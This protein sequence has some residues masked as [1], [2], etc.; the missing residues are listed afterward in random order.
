MRD[1]VEWSRSLAGAASRTSSAD[2]HGEYPQASRMFNSAV[3]PQAET[4]NCTAELLRISSTLLSH[5]DSTMPLS[6]PSISPIPHDLVFSVPRGSRRHS[7]GGLL[8]L[9]LPAAGY[10][11]N[12]STVD[13]QQTVP[14]CVPRRSPQV[15]NQPGAHQKSS[16]HQESRTKRLPW[17]AAAETGERLDSANESG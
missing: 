3:G 15:N 12:C 6:L 13:R 10:G 4:P 8:E 14:R 1:G 9:Y 11:L 16:R 7:V 2:G 5:A 17:E